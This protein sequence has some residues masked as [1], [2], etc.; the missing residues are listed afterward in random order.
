MKRYHLSLLLLML[1]LLAGCG[2]SKPEAS[3]VSAPED[4]SW[5]TLVVPSP[6][7]L[8]ETETVLPELDL[9]TF[10]QEGEN[11]TDDYKEAFLGVWLDED[12]AYSYEFLPNENLVVTRLST[13]RADTY[14]YWFLQQNG[15]VR[16]Y[17][18][19]NGEEAPNEYS[20]TIDG[21]NLTF[22][23]VNNGSAVEA[24]T[25]KPA[26]TPAPAP[27]ET[28]AETPAPTATPTPTPEPSAAP[29][30]APTPEP[31]PSPEPTPSPSAEP[32]SSPTP[33]LPQ[34]VE[35]AMSRVECALDAVAD[36]MSF[37]SGDP[38]S[39]WNIMA[40]YLSRSHEGDEE[41][42]MVLSQ[43]RVAVF[44]EEIF[45]DFS[46]VPDCPQDSG[47][48]EFLPADNEQEDRYKVLWGASGG[49]ELEVLAYDEAAA[50]LTVQV[51][52]GTTYAVVINE[53]GAI[54]SIQ[55]V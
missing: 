22:Y 12:S 20:F 16:L 49:N 33:V 35:A 9:D 5:E 47:I 2:T 39:F 4:E 31:S 28:A 27:A 17:S 18:F 50:S 55:A 54:V 11:V 29:T 26:E 42:Y 24:L 30:E 14:T 37:S 25:R 1:L 19:L 51:N 38:V 53:N 13:G 21:Q 32:S 10:E 45:A 44:A 52:G 8:P 48:V 23:D 7:A 3:A 6:S 41:G 46:A 43:A 36:G 15:Q 34:H 40:R